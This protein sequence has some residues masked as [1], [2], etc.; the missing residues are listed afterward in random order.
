VLT[1]CNDEKVI[2][3]FFEGPGERL[4][5]R[6]VARRTGLSP[7]GAMKILRRLKNEG[8]LI[9]EPNNVV[10]N[11][12][13]NYDSSRFVA[14]K[15]LTNLFSL[16]ECGLIEELSKHYSLPECIVL[17]GSYARGEDTTRSDIAI[18]IVTEM[19]DVPQLH[20]YEKKLNR[21]ISIHTIS[22]LKEEDSNFRNSLAN[23]IVLSGY[24]EV[25]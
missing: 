8:L 6:E 18:A 16:Y 9:E 10:V 14:L 1:G 7:P 3:L 25:T 17:F 22:N 2:K 5:V 19:D 13:G 4:H 15:R 24:L 23:G 20:K 12:R 21:K 11:Y